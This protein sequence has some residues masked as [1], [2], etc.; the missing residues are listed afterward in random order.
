MKL[1]IC[2][3]LYLC[4]NFIKVEVMEYFIYFKRCII[5]AMIM[6]KSI[7]YEEYYIL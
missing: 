7:S 6:K 1:V 5:F 2:L 4:N 3:L